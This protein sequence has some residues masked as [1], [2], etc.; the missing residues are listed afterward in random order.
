MCCHFDC[1]F[2]FHFSLQLSLFCCCHASPFNCQYHF[3]TSLPY[4]EQP[5]TKPARA[6]QLLWQSTLVWECT[7]KKNKQSKYFCGRL[8]KT[9]PNKLK[10]I[11]E[12]LQ[13]SFVKW[14]FT[15]QC[16]HSWMQFATSKQRGVPAELLTPDL[17]LLRTGHLFFKPL[18]PQKKCNIV[19]GWI[20]TICALQWYLGG[21]LVFARIS[22]IF[23][24]NGFSS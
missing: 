5:P 3:S 21:A 2:S 9:Y 10:D 8:G 23:F 18:F 24:E 11:L 14:V 19:L 15:M 6:A 20:S 16:L 13:T 1:N 12:I 7:R 4:H 17:A 22:T